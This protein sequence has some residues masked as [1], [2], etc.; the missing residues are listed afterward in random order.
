VSGQTES[1]RGEFSVYG[2]DLPVVTAD[3]ALDS[4]VRA[5]NGQTVQRS[6]D[7]SGGFS[8]SFGQA[9][10]MPMPLGLTHSR[11]VEKIVQRVENNLSRSEG[12]SSS[13]L[14]SAQ[15]PAMPSSAN[16]PA[17]ATT[18]ETMQGPGEILALADQVYV[19]I[20]ERLSVE[21]ESLGL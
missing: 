15:T 18:P 9:M 21:R 4:P 2:K 5:G 12:A 6:A 16:I 13:S 20:M 8:G 10:D 1:I 14:S 7:N 11:V 19:L 17:P 3:Y